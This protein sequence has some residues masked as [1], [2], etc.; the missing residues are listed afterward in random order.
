[1]SDTLI[2]MLSLLAALQRECGVALL[3]PENL[4]HSDEAESFEAQ[5]ALTNVALE[6]AQ[7]N[8]PDFEALLPDRFFESFALR[9]NAA[10]RA[11][12]P[13]ENLA[14]W[15]LFNLEQPVYHLVLGLLT[16]DQ[17]F[18]PVRASAFVHFAAALGRLRQLRDIG[19]SV[20][21]KMEVMPIDARKLKS[22]A[23]SFLAREKLFL[24]LADETLKQMMDETKQ[25]PLFVLGEMDQILR[26]LRDGLGVEVLKTT[27]LTTWL[28]VFNDELQT[29]HAALTKTLTRL[30][31]ENAE[32]IAQIGPSAAIDADVEAHLEIIEILPVFRGLSEST[33]RGV[34]KGARLIDAKKNE[35]LI[36]QGDPVSRFFILMDGW[37]KTTK[38]SAEGQEAVMQIMGKKECLLDMGLMGA[39]PSPVSVKTI[40]AARVLSLSLPALRDYASRNRELAQNL[41]ALTTARLARLAAQYEQVTLRTAEQRV[42]WF[43]INLHLET[44]L[45]GAPLKLPFD[46]ALI[47]SYLN[48]KPETFS[49]V[50]QTFRARG[51][52]I[53]KYQV[54]MPEPRALCAYC[55]PEMALRCCRA[56]AVNCA[57]IIAARRA[58]GRG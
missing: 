54:I 7:K 49:R 40:T 20:Y 38:T 21:A 13:P 2:Q 25:T 53:D 46:K 22:A 35:V 36:A 17:S 19:L 15:Y 55:D 4:T 6:T 8:N 23:A 30:A 16:E 31:A 5:A 37:A 51:F 18:A 33:L 43:L 42:G 9:N 57:P 26:K 11:S 39:V 1:M 29:L 48:I 44:G 14:E 56:E 50:L 45:E 3:A 32:S 24:G 34:L 28:R 27:P 10:F 47:A 41:L 58:E 52:L 12:L